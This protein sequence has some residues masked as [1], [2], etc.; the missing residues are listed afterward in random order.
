MKLIFYKIH[1]VTN[2][3]SRNLFV[4][5]IMCVCV[6][7]LYILYI[8]IYT[9]QLTKFF[10]VVIYIYIYKRDLHRKIYIYTF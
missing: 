9:F 1:F 10:V 5:Y 2:Y 7:F 8:Y 3:G 4:L 6:S